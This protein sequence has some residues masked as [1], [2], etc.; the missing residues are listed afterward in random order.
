MGGSAS[1]SIY[2]SAHQSLDLQLVAFQAC[3]SCER[4]ARR[5]T[6]SSVRERWGS[7]TLIRPQSDRGCM[8]ATLDGSRSPSIVAASRSS[9][10]SRL[11]SLLELMYLTLLLILIFL[12]YLRF[13]DK[14]VDAVLTL[15]SPPLFQLTLIMPWLFARFWWNERR[16][17]QPLQASTHS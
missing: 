4:R 17:M 1:K 9:T 7:P 16:C 10:S 12:S 15:N 2:G 3:C 11:F 8:L 14:H 5:G 6:R 13:I